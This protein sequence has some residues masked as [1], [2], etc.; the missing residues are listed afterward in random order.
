MNIT[1]RRS[2]M[3]KEQFGKP[4]DDV[5]ARPAT[6]RSIAP[7]GTV[8]PPTVAVSSAHEAAGV[9]STT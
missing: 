7:H 1:S 6:V 3:V 9:K 5:V 2:R 4:V 8:T